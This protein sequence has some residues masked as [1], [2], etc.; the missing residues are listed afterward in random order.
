M[1]SKKIGIDLGTANV[2][3]CSLNSKEIKYDN[4]LL[5]LDSN[6]NDYVK[7][8]QE[9]TDLIGKVGDDLKIIRPVKSGILQD[10]E[11]QKE[12][13]TP[14]IDSFIGSHRIVK[15]DFLISIPR[16]IRDSDRNSIYTLIEDLGGSS[17]SYL[18]PEIIL[19][20]IGLKL[21]IYSPT[22][23][24]LVNLGA[25]TT[26]TAVLSLG[27]INSSNTLNFGGDDLDQLIV[28]YFKSNNILIGSKTAESLKKYFLSA[29]IED[30]NEMLE[31]KG[32]ELSSGKAVI[33]H[34]KKDDLRIAVLPGIEK[35]ANSIKS[36]IE[37]LPPELSGDILDKGIILTGG[38][39]RLKKLNVFLTSYLGV[40][41]YVL[42]GAED[43]AVNGL[44]HLIDNID[45]IPKYLRV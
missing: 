16:I 41:V 10:I 39:S 42:D 25:G 2:R 30:K 5:I 29:E 12:L 9:A 26:E 34:F 17:Q 44:K 32:K 4:N 22:G 36:V 27:G 14:L 38:L 35:I 31:I 33:Y 19:S 23:T 11:A 37:N 8:G 21:P 24:A 28:D 7:R 13:L 40:P 18:I 15:P 20:A 6:T 43:S 45:L 3:V 1:F